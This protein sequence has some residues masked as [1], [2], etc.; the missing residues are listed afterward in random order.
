MPVQWMEEVIPF[1]GDIEIAQAHEGQIPMVSLRL[2][3]G[4]VEAKPDPDG[5]MRELDLDVVIDLDI[6]LYEE[7]EEMLLSRSTLQHDEFV[8]AGY[9]SSCFLIADSL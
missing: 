5:Q 3:H 7:K 6:R 2:A 4:E 1:S 9:T 8:L